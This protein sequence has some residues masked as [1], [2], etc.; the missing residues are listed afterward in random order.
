[1][2]SFVFLLDPTE[3][4]EQLLQVSKRLISYKDDVHEPT[5]VDVAFNLPPYVVPS[6]WNRYH[7]SAHDIKRQAQYIPAKLYWMSA[8]WQ[9]IDVI[10]SAIKP[11]FAS[12]QD[13]LVLCKPLAILKIVGNPLSTI[14]QLVKHNRHI[15]PPPTAVISHEKMQLLST[16][17]FHE[18][19]PFDLNPVCSLFSYLGTNYVAVNMNDDGILL[20]RVV[21]INVF[22]QSTKAKNTLATTPILLEVANTIYA[23]VEDCVLVN[24]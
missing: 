13:I 20:K 8:L 23:V 5:L 9:G 24:C 3:S 6:Y 10:A 15:P 17:I 22:N 14:S 2:T 18:L 21:P 7:L 11:S 12:P 1:M 19:K 16:M 4:C